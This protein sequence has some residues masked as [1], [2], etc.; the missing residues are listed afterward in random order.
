MRKDV[1]DGSKTFKEKKLRANCPPKT[2]KK[3]KGATVLE[4]RLANVF[5][6]WNTTLL[7]CSSQ[8]P[9]TTDQNPERL[10]RELPLGITAVVQANY[11]DSKQKTAE[12]ENFVLSQ[13]N[14]S[15]QMFS[16]CCFGAAASPKMTIRWYVKKYESECFFSKKAVFSWYFVK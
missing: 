16:K 2:K 4:A 1:V 13:V 8:K 5:N 15:Q 7:T 11:L 3:H 12:K 9:E 10:S 6:L 14:Q